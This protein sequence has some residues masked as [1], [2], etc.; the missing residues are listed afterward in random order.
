MVRRYDHGEIVGE[1]DPDWSL[2]DL[3][4]WCKKE[5]EGGHAKRNKES[6]DSHSRSY[7]NG[8]I[9]ALQSVL[10]HLEALPCSDQPV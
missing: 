9:V 10:I 4:A 1:K 6:V 7:L 2:H 5:I 8:R 3:I